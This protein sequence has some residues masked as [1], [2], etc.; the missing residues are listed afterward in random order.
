MVD[1]VVGVSE[2]RDGV[3]LKR[4]TKGEVG[5][6]VFG[7]YVHK[8]TGVY[9]ADFELALDG[10]PDVPP[11]T[12]CATLEVTT[13]GGDL[14]LAQRPVLVGELSTS[15]RTLPLLAATYHIHTLEFR[16][17]A[18]GSVA[19]LVRNPP[20]WRRVSAVMDVVPD[21]ELSASL[22]QGVRYA[23]DTRRILRSLQPR[24]LESHLKVR[25]GKDFDGGYIC[26]DD[27]SGID[28][29]FSFGIC[30]DISW[31]QAIADR[32]LTIYQFDHTVTDPAPNDPRM[33]F[34][35]KMISSQSSDQ[36]QSLADLIRTHDRGREKPNLILKMDIEGAEW[37]VLAATPADALAR[38]AWIVCELHSFQLMADTRLRAKIDVC[39]QKLGLHFDV[40]HLHSNVWGG[41]STHA[42]VVVP[43]VLEVTFANRSVYRTIVG[44]Q[45]YPTSLDQTCDPAQPDFYLG[46]F[47]Y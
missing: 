30:D 1:A 28:K 8:T 37:D 34:E 17:R 21:H 27:T 4:T 25:L 38:L 2:V 46:M 36:S 33:I 44:A 9:Q 14:K 24:D 19:L 41:Y 31:D 16:V 5:Y 47:A 11:E 45:T 13:D 18:H 39:L 7:P 42:N 29:A 32:G 10:A 6:P 40:V 15:F 43:N 20:S 26:P 22:G 12:V 35:Q 3:A 23:D